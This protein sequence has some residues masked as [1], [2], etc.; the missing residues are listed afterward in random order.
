MKKAV[1]FGAGNIGRGFLG[2]L[3]SQSG[4]ETVFVDIDRRVVDALNQRRSYT[5]EIAEEKIQTITIDKV[6][7]IHAEDSERVAEELKDADIAATAVGNAALPQI[8][9]LVTKGIQRRADSESKYPLNIILCENL[10]NAAKIFREY[11]FSHLE[12]SYQAY[13]EHNLGLVES[14]VSRMVPILPEEIRR[15]DPAFVRVEKYCTLPVDGTAF[16]GSTP[17]IKGMVLSPNI[18]AYERRKIYTHNAGH[19]ICAYLGYL[20]GYTYIWE[21]LKSPEIYRMV[22]DALK[23]TGR[24]LIEQEKFSPKEQWQHVEDLLQRFSNR[25]L[26]D[27]VY[28]VGRDPLRKLAKEDRLIGSATLAWKYK[29]EPL[30]VCK[31]IAAALKYDCKEDAQAVKLQSYLQSKGM[32]WVLSSVCEL[33][34]EGKIGKLVKQFYK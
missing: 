3:F 31:G 18:K 13:V 34:P 12:E 23:E 20:K 4:Y 10:L 14:V 2:Q 25:V 24:A 17:E 33:E 8:A 27:T 16:K 11:V 15:K 19:A 22:R 6:R 1:Q 28:R 30:N 5:I 26:E 7:A 21:S 29:I 32:D 9:P